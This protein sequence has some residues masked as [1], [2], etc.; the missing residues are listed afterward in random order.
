MGKKK[1]DDDYLGL[2]GHIK[3]SGLFNGTI[4][5]GI[6]ENA[7][8]SV[9]KYE[10]QDDAM[11]EEALIKSKKEELRNRIKESELREAETIKREKE[12]FKEGK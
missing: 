6:Q 1:K 7:R 2:G 10:E 8:R 4:L 11:K 3:E 9:R 12:K 5:Y